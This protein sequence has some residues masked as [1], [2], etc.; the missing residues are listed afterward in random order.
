M[1]LNE[2]WIILMEGIMK[3]EVHETSSQKILAHVKWIFCP[4]DGDKG[5]HFKSATGI[6]F[7]ASL[8]NFT[9]FL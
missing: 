9:L 3:M 2:D 7:L 4:L 6:Y 5:H 8:I 1:Q